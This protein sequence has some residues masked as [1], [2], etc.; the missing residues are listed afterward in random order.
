MC[1]SQLSVLE[2]EREVFTDEPKKQIAINSYS[3]DLMLTIRLAVDVKQT[4]V[5]K[6]DFD[7]VPF[8]FN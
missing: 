6:S 8:V 7:G 2:H 3:R 1:S 5:N 4:L